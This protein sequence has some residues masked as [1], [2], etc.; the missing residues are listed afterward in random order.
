M[1]NIKCFDFRSSYPAVM[2]SC[3]FPVGTWK[4]ATY[5]FAKEMAIL[6]YSERPYA[7]YIRAKFYDV[8]SKMFNSFW[9]ESKC[10]DGS[11]VYCTEERNGREVIKK[12]TIDNGKIHEI[13]EMEA[14]MTDR[15]LIICRKK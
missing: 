2:C 12:G 4:H 1:E 8:K 3:K 10:V 7:Y 15:G 14:V 5:D 6:P 9:S 13:K 11:M